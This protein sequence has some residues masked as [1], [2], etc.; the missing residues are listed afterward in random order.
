MAASSSHASRSFTYRD[1]YLVS[2]VAAIDVSPNATR[3]AHDAAA[4]YSEQFRQ[5]RTVEAM[6]TAQHLQGARLPHNPSHGLC[7]LAFECT[8][9]HD[10]S[11]PA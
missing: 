5:P 7:S 1:T 2:S 3:P 4:P 11:F 6:Q 8:L 9:I 10:R